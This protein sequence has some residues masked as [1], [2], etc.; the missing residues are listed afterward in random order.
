[1]S[2]QEREGLTNLPGGGDAD[3]LEDDVEG[4]GLREIAAGM[5]IAGSVAVGGHQLLSSAHASV[6][7]APAIHAQNPAAPVV[8]PALPPISPPGTGDAV[9]EVNQVG[10]TVLPRTW[11]NEVVPLEAPVLGVAGGV[12]GDVTNDVAKDVGDVT[13]DAARLAGTVVS[14]AKGTVN[15]ALAQA[16]G[17]VNAT[18]SGAEQNV[19]NPALRSVTSDVNRTL[20]QAG[21]TVD[22]TVSGAVDPLQAGAGYGQ[23][24]SVQVSGGT[25]T[26]SAAG[27][28]TSADG[29]V[30][31]RTPQLPAEDISTQPVPPVQIP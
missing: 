21:G 1:M 3:G 25:A 27:T 2:D 19:V 11:G 12:V 5:A 31:L 9:N 14:T 7:S 30:H 13:S 17:T 10:S 24:A 28:G 22:R 20:A 26:V 16:T 8:A 18:V 29:N 4:H 23:T 15:P 6:P